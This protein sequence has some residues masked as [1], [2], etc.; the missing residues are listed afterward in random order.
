MKKHLILLI[1][2][3]SSAIN[4]NAQVKVFSN[5]N[6]GV[7]TNLDS[8]SA[9]LSVGDR[10]Y[11]TDYNISLL[12]SAPAS[13]NYNIGIEGA[14]CPDSAVTGHNYGVRGIAGGNTEGYNYGVMGKLDGTAGGAGVYGTTGNALGGLVDGRY[15]GYFD[16]DLGVTGVSKMQLVN[17]YDCDTIATNNDLSLL[18]SIFLLMAIKGVTTTD[19][20]GVTHYGLATDIL[21]DSYPNL[22]VTD[23]QG[24]KYANYT[25]IIPVVAAGVRE[26]FEFYSARSQSRALANSNPWDGGTDVIQRI[27]R[28]EAALSQNSPNPF[29]GSTVVSYQLP[30]GTGEAHIVITDMQGRPIARQPLDTGSSRATISADGIPPGMYIY[31]LVADNTAIGTKRMIINK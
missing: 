16:G 7:G 19:S 9:K 26:I 18:Q 4:A 2:L 28:N 6:V 25:E 13:G 15:A 22:I 31:T 11:G 12:S 17:I 3:V 8:V 23:A 21:E 1:L 14:A 5:G 30:E 24:R 20:A 27:V 10:Q 29:S